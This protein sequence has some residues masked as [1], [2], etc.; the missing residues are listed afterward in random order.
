[1]GRFQLPPDAFR[2]KMYLLSFR[3]PLARR[4]LVPEKET[5]PHLHFP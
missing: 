4:Q 3:L 1:M 2:Y 5:P